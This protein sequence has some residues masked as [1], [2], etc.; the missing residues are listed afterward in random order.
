MV[1]ALTAR[2]DFLR[3]AA[4]GQLTGVVDPGRTRTRRNHTAT[5]LLHAALRAVLGGHVRQAGSLVSPERL[6]FDYAHFESVRP[7]QLRAIE[8]MVNAW[9]LRDLPVT[10]EEKSLQEARAAGAMA[11]F[12]EKYGATVRMVRVAG[13]EGQADVSRELCGGTHVGRTGEIGLFV[14]LSE[15][16]IASGTRRIE[17][18]TGEGA[19]EHARATRHALAELARGLNTREDQIAARI[20][21]LKEE[22][23]TL[24]KREQERLRK[25]ALGAAPGGSGGAA[26]YQGAVNGR[27]WRVLRVE[28]DSVNL[29]REL[30]DQARAALGSGCAVVAAEVGGKLSVVAV[31][32]DDLVAKGLRADG[33][34]R[35]IVA[36]AGG[37]GGGKPHQALAGVKDPGQ[38]GLI[39][40]KAREVLERELQRLGA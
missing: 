8:D 28:A 30:G 29:L 4:D 31:V 38:W 1:A 26:A 27:H 18:L 15:A 36:V 5:H 24:R 14:V 17:A 34:V 7:G 12:G 11:L 2:N 23:G 40:D 39:E 35:E 13:A 3:A 6:R 33:L 20:E 25:Q 9:V 37:S 21:A 32:T 10:T 16:G 19:L 22:I